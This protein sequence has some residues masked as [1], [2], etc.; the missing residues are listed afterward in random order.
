[1]VASDIESSC[2]HEEPG[3]LGATGGAGS[4]EVGSLCCIIPLQIAQMCTPRTPQAGLTDP[5]AMPH[6]IPV[7]AGALRLR[8]PGKTMV[9]PPT[10]SSHILTMPQLGDLEYLM[11]FFPFLICQM[12]TTTQFLTLQGFYNQVPVLDGVLCKNAYN[13]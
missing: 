5:W 4:A 1:M 9:L 11:S 8:S 13:V 12:G 3:V 7:H 10:L 2:V 6:S